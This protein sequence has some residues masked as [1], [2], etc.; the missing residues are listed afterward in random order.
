AA[1]RALAELVNEARRAHGLPAL[2][3]DPRLVAVARAHST[4]MFRLEYFGHQSPVSGSPFDRLD[5]AEI[6]YTRAGENL[7]YAHSVAIAHRGLMDS[8]GHRANILRPEFTRIG[9][10][11]ISA[12][13]YGRMFTQLFLTP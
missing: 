7:A 1:E 13:P 8:P 12:G 11:A 5:A 6:A 10:G 3:I 2:T 9:V 4:E